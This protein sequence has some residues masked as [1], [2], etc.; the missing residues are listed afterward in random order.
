[1]VQTKQGKVSFYKINSS[2]IDKVEKFISKLDKVYNSFKNKKYN[3]IPTLEINDDKYYIQSMQKR[4]LEEKF[5]NEYLY[6]WLITISRVDLESNIIVADLSKNIN[7]RRRELEHD[8]NE[9]LVVDTRILVEPYGK[10]LAVHNKRGTIGL[11]DLRRFICKLIDTNGIRLDIILNEEGYEGVKNLDVA[12]KIEYTIASPNNFKAFKDDTR[13]EL[14]DLNVANSLGGDDMKVSISS[15]HL[16]KE[17]LFDKIRAIF[18]AGE[19]EVEVKNFKIEGYVD[20]DFQVID[21]IKNKLI[22]R[23]DIEYDEK[24][25][26]DDRAVFGLLNKAYDYY[27]DFL[28]RFRVAE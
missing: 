14:Y 24:I 26:I 21:M 27:S 28:A 11:T 1:M 18:F 23:G 7:E 22:Y 2:K 8:S 25:G 12:S 13:S 9:G 17:K 19:N 4:V 15:K 20:G 16:K 3:E 10:I 6:Y 5:N